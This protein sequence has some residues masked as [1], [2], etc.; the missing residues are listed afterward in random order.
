MPMGGLK[1]STISGYLEGPTHV[2]VLCTHTQKWREAHW[3]ALM[4]LVVN[5]QTFK[6]DLIPILHRVL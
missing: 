3:K 6:K 5:V 1:S 4:V 2:Q